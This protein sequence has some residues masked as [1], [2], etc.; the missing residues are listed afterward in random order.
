[1]WVTGGSVDHKKMLIEQNKRGPRHFIYWC[2]CP[3]LSQGLGSGPE[4]QSLCVTSRRW[5][6]AFVDATAGSG[7]RSTR[8]IEQLPEICRD[9]IEGQM[10]SLNSGYEWGVGSE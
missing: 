2:Y 8:D 4:P 7:R 9:S 1:M 3:H 5:A 6:S 10:N